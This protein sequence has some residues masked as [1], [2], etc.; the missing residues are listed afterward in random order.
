MKTRIISIRNDFA[1][2]CRIRVQN[3]PPPPPHNGNEAH[4]RK[5]A[6]ELGQ[7]LSMRCLRRSTGL[8]GDE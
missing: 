7:A 4:V 2:S 6:W 8:A 1:Q 5:T 3:W